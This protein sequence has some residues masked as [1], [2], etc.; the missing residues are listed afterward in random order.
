[1]LTMLLGMVMNVGRDVD[2][3]IRLQNTADAVALSGGTVMARGLNVLAF[4]NHLL[5]DVCA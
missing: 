5:F 2:A 3:K 1:M 4:T